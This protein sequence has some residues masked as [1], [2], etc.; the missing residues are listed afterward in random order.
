MKNRYKKSIAGRVSPDI[1]NRVQPLIEKF[2][3]EHQLPFNT[4][5]GAVMFTAEQLKGRVTCARVEALV[6]VDTV[7]G[8]ERELQ[9][10]AEARKLQITGIIRRALPA[11]KRTREV[12]DKLYS[13]FCGFRG[14]VPRL[15]Q[16]V[17]AAAAA[18]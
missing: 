5:F 14:S 1:R 16:Q 11:A 13:Q 12:I 6:T 2:A 17:Q 10:R 8:Y 3:Q 9:R 4:V 18:G 15:Q 7:Q